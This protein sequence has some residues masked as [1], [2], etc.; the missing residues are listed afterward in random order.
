MLVS[1]RILEKSENEVRLCPMTLSTTNDGESVFLQAHAYAPDEINRRKY[2]TNI[3]DVSESIF[4]FVR[5]TQLV[6]VAPILSNA[7]H[8]SID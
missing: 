4:P 1:V 6:A 7:Y 5:Q 2:I 3:S 8:I